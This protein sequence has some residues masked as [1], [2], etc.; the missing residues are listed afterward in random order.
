MCRLGSASRDWQNSKV[1]KQQAYIV[2]TKANRILIATLLSVVFAAHK[3]SAPAQAYKSW[4]KD[5]FCGSQS[6]V[7]AALAKRLAHMNYCLNGPGRPAQNG[8]YVR[9]KWALLIGVNR[10]QDSSIK[11]MRIA[12]NDIAL[13]SA[14]LKE[15]TVG[16]FPSDHVYHLV[17][18]SATRDAIQ[19]AIL[20]SFLIKKALPSDLIF[21]YF[22]ARMLPLFDE[23]DLCICT[24]DT[25]ASEASRSGVR[26]AET[27]SNLRKRTQCGQIVCVLDCASVSKR[28]FSRGQALSLE[29]LSKKTG[30]SLIAAGDLSEETPAC[31]GGMF[32]SFALYLANALRAS[33]GSSSLATLADC[34]QSDLDKASGELGTAREAVT[35]IPAV[36]N[37]K[38]PDLVLGAPIRRASFRKRVAVGHEVGSL[39]LDR[40][41][42][43][44]SAPQRIAAQPSRPRIINGKT[45]DDDD[46]SARFSQVDYGPWMDKMK[47]DIK[48]KWQPPKGLEQ[49]HVVAVFSIKRDGSIVEPSIVES[50]GIDAV[51]VSA[52][53]ALKAASP[54]DPLPAGAPPSV[55]IRYVFDWRVERN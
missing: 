48:A 6:R 4:G 5:V 51:D 1:R 15:P 39:A 13:M 40:P 49:R 37:V 26:L 2:G 32:S 42:L 55:Q 50:S 22:S 20:D 52:L 38:A 35:F 30:V 11:P 28:D 16:R 7:Q 44:A 12:R 27:L 34:V 41:D 46:E 54:L 43:L 45:P 9:D 18:R 8:L 25:L 21:L 36:N 17:G 24:Y 14:V 53:N 19:E 10:Y 31:S 33:S 47:R 29:E 3:F 23:N